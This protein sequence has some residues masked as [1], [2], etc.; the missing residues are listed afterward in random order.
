M[1]VVS[2]RSSVSSLIGRFDNNMNLADKNNDSISINLEN[3]K[4]AKGNDLDDD[5]SSIVSN[6]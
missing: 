1:S 2:K 6:A 5:N 4:N 3:N